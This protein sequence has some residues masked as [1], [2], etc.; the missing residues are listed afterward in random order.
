MTDDYLALPDDLVEYVTDV[1]SGMVLLDGRWIP[2]LDPIGYTNQARLA[3][4]VTTGDYSKESDEILSSSVKVSTIGG[5]QQLVETEGADDDRFY[6]S[7][8]ET[9]FAGQL[10]L[11]QE[12]NT[13]PYTA[14]SG[15]VESSVAYPLGDLIISDSETATLVAFGNRFGRFT[16]AGTFT[17][18]G[19]LPTSG[20]PTGKGVMF[21]DRLYVPFGA[22]GYAHISSGMVATG[23]SLGGGVGPMFFA[24]WDDK[25]VCIDSQRY[26]RMGQPTGTNGALV[27]DA[28]VSRKRIPFGFRPRRFLI[29]EDRG[30][31]PMIH[32]VTDRDVWAY[33]ARAGR[34]VR[35]SLTYPP[36]P[37]TGVA[38]TSWRGKGY[39]AVAVGVYEY[40][41]A[42]GTQS[43][44]GLDRDSGLPAHLR[45]R[46]V[47]MEPEHNGLYALVEGL[48]TVA[49]TD[50][51]SYSAPTDLVDNDGDAAT[52]NTE[53]GSYYDQGMY[54]RTSQVNASLHCFTEAGWHKIWES[55]GVGNPSW[56]C[57]SA[58]AALNETPK[59]R[60]LWGFGNNLHYIELRRSFH[61]PREG[62]KAKQDRFRTTGRHLTSRFNAGMLG[63][64]KLASHMEVNTD[65]ATDDA[66]VTVYYYTDRSPYSPTLLGEATLGPEGGV[67]VLPFGLNNGF[68]EGVPFNW[69]QFEYVFSSSDP[70][71]T[72][73]V[74][75]FVLYFTKLSN[76]NSKSWTLRIPA[77]M[78]EDWVG[79]GH[80]EL[81]RFLDEKTVDARFHEMIVGGPKA[82]EDGTAVRY[83]VR[84]SQTQGVNKSGFDASGNRVINV[85]EIPIPESR[86]RTTEDEQ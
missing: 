74:D 42:G 49:G 83:R 7:D 2:V 18:V 10:T 25:L 68:S 47:D 52:F 40:T 36:H 73:V 14:M 8:L 57:V 48:N 61:T 13:V 16:T 64:T 80:D 66:K 63:Y 50:Y 76:A 32:V 19:A 35:T 65:Y 55:G 45:G 17:N 75:S 26:L 58:T 6:D 15:A 1:E 34:L 56:V 78:P 4:K 60:L 59:Y 84:V 30:G 33:N 22:T 69:I 71:E 79:M 70:T 5:G 51:E 72:P 54:F 11:G 67:N 39:V 86:G 24:V 9:R 12:I 85:I 44:I 20:I 46:I 23:D 62:R 38:A 3:P 27:W 37:D 82:V 43:A 31:E 21:N 53:E 41:G 28:Q 77:H 29:I 81:Q